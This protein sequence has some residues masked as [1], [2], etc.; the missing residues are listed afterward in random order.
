VIGV[1]EALNPK[2]G[3]FDPDTLLML[4]GIG[5]LAG[6]AIRH[7]QLFKQLQ[8]AHQSYQDLF[9][10][11]IDPILITDWDGKILDANRKA[12][13]FSDFSKTDLGSLDITQIHHINRKFVG[14][15]YSLL[16]SGKTISYESHLCTASGHEVP[17]NVYVRE[18]QLDN[19]SHLQWILRDI[20]EQKKLDTL[21]D[22]LISMIYHDL[23][24]P[25]ANV[26]SS[27]D[28]LDTMLPSED[29]ELK[30]LLDISMRSAERIQRMTESLLDLT[31]L[32]TGRPIGTRKQTSM[33]ALVCE[34]VEGVEALLHNKGQ[35]ISYKVPERLPNVFADQDMIRRVMTNL[36]ENASKYAPQGSTIEV[37]A[38]Q[39]DRQVLVWVKD[40]GPGIP[41]S[42]RER[43]FNKF[44]RLKTEN[45][46]KGL[47]LGLA[48]CRLAVQAHGGRI[49]VESEV[50]VGSCF[51]FTL[52]IA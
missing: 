17:I 22:D 20:T 11:S 10:D 38:R 40:C 44:T 36:I 34:A 19:V 14:E 7:A 4:S 52:P 33:L 9:E 27:L 31:L 45:A 18:I 5:S 12:V 1:L 24:S 16:R 50:G 6:T 23:R 47:G 46:P 49:W 37:G 2:R 3:F 43:I 51:S 32:E 13:V 28:L 21:R 29:P 26:I 30:S 25:L 48:Y 42:E 35:I 15:D 39:E 41:A 8:A